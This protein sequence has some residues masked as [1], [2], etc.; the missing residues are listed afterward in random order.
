MAC[1]FS[2]S[3]RGV[4]LHNV[5]GWDADNDQSQFCKPKEPLHVLMMM[6]QVCCVPAAQPVLVPSPLGNGGS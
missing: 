4:I 3:L 6:D 5:R 2:Q 1:K